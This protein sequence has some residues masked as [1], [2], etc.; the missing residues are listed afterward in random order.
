MIK[1]VILF[2]LVMISIIN[3]VHASVQV[4]IAP[5]WER[6]TD[7]TS[8]IKKYLSEINYNQNVIIDSSDSGVM[9]K[10]LNKY[11][12]E[13]ETYLSN[14][15]PQKDTLKYKGTFCKVSF[16]SDKT[17]PEVINYPEVVS[18][19]FF[20]DNTSPGCKILTRELVKIVKNNNL[21]YPYEI[22]KEGLLSINMIYVFK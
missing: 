18:F 16:T 19:D 17:S 4:Y 1:I 14:D 5:S 15:F 21:I 10:T 2:V 11:R 9:K 22:K 7:S 3:S 20:A 12:K 13:I 8:E 6:R